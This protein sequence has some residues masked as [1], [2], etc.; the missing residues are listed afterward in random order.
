MNGL[1]VAVEL[2]EVTK[3]YGNLRAL[4]SVSTKI[5]EGEYV[6]LLGHNGAGKTTLLKI[7]ATHSSPSSGT[8]SIF[9][10]NAFKA[11]DEIRRRIGF[12]A[13]ESF[14]YDELTVEE[15]L[16]FYAKLFS[17]DWKKSSDLVEFLKLRNRSKTRVKH[18]SHGLRKRADIVRALI[19][20]PDLILMDEL[21]SG[22]DSE[23]C[24][25]LVDHFKNQKGKTILVS[26]HSKYWAKQLATR[27][28]ILKK[29]K[30]Q[31]DIQ[32]G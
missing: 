5:Y 22:L 31:Q 21:F 15:N 29:G 26:S 24:S 9:G 18:L 19:H 3:K 2:A 13:H 8:V 11:A 23:T 28:I 4:N 16:R 30:I 25:L 17:V 14:L 12:V 1:A 6:A 7:L 20:N 32:L 27:G 10:I